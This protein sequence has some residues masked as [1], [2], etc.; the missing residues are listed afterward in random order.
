MTDDLFTVVWQFFRHEMFIEFIFCIWSQDHNDFTMVGQGFEGRGIDD[1]VTV[2]NECDDGASGDGSELEIDERFADHFMGDMDLNGEESFDHGVDVPLFE[3]IEEHGGGSSCG[4]EDKIGASAMERGDV[5]FV[6]AS[7]EE[8]DIRAQFSEVEGEID[9]DIV[10]VS[11]DEDGRGVE[12]QGRFEEFVIGGVTDDDILS[13]FA[14]SAACWHFLV[15]DGEGGTFCPEVTSGGESDVAGAENDDA[16]AFDFIAW[17]L[18]VIGVHLFL[19]E[20][21]DEDGIFTDAGIGTS[22]IEFTAFPDADDSDL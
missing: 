2:L 16:I 9:V 10:V 11:G 4:R 12:E 15:D 1:A 21:H 5:I 6:I 14:S 17:E 3:M 22:E 8:L 20:S 18:V 19:P 13:K 7:C